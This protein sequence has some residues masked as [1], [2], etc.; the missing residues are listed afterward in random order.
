MGSQ[1]EL[2]KRW[3]AC[4]CLGDEA[5]AAATA[6]VY[7]EGVLEGAGVASCSVQAPDWLTVGGAEVLYLRGDEAAVRVLAT[8]RIVAVKA[9]ELRFRAAAPAGWGVV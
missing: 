8:G 5:A 9:T 2:V 1:R 7:N 3:A 6:T 4:V